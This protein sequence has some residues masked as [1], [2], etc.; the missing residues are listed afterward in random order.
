VSQFQTPI[1]SDQRSYF[2]TL[3]AWPGLT[4]ETTMGAV[5]KRTTV[6]NYTIF[7]SGPNWTL[8][9]TDDADVKALQQALSE[10]QAR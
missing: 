1:P 9:V 5:G 8:E 10:S 7:T 2:D 4:T 6:A 3:N